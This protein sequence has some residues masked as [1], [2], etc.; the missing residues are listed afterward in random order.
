MKKLKKVIALVLV[1]AMGIS[2]AACGQK[3]ETPS[4]TADTADTADAADAPTTESVPP[5]G[6]DKEIEITITHFNIE[7]QRDGNADYDGFYSM[8][9]AWQT[10]HPD[11][12]I[13]QSV[14]E[15]SDL[16]TKIQ[17][18]A[19]ADDLPDLFPVKGSWFKNFV[20][21]DLLSPVTGVIDSYEK[22]D[23]FREGVFDAATVDGEIYGMPVQFSVSSLVFY[24]K[25]MW[26]EIG[27]DSFPDNWDDV[28]AAIEKFN[29]KGIT[30]FAF[31]NSAKWPAESCI[32]SAIGDRYTGAEWTNNIIANNGQSQFTD[33]EFV[34]ALEHL[35]KLAEAG[36]FNADFNVASTGQA[37]EMY[38][39]GM[40]ATI[41]NGFWN[42]ANVNANATEEVKNS[43]GIAILPPVE[44]GKGNT[45]STSGGCGWYMGMSKQE[46]PEKKALI[47]DLLLHLAGY[48]YSE[49]IAEK[50]GLVTPSIVENVDTSSFPPATQEYIELMNNV[51]LTP[52]YDILMDAAVIEVM[53]TGVQE[54]LNGTKTAAD[55]AAEIQAEQE[56]LEK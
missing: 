45:N 9:E 19:A 50:Y 41:I 34:S 28:Y 24:N 51:Q 27:Y 46:D 56:S 44:G 10:E 12:K 40:A 4:T 1:L 31:G 33:P 3:Q 16:E 39:T 38:N 8:L 55:L 37:G 15:T 22:K 47:E 36:A 54:M 30:P 32:L 53:N 20:S 26:K 18:Q 25:T 11:V 29:E 13:T 23:A 2:L 42:I 43:T 7:E 35:Q 5:S 21:S 48:E 6:G 17:A 49:F 14:L 52:I